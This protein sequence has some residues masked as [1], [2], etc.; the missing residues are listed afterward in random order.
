MESCLENFYSVSNDL[1]GDIGSDMS[2]LTQILKMMQEKDHQQSERTYAK[3]SGQV[4]ALFR[5][6]S[7]QNSSTFAKQEFK[8]VVLKISIF[9]QKC[10]QMFERQLLELSHMMDVSLQAIFLRENFLPF[11]LKK[12][13]ILIQGNKTTSKGTRKHRKEWRILFELTKTFKLEIEILSGKS[14]M[15]STNAYQP[16][17][18]ELQG[19]QERISTAVSFYWKKTVISKKQAE[20]AKSIQKVRKKLNSTHKQ[21]HPDKNK[22]SEIHRMIS[23][24][25]FEVKRLKTI[26]G[27]YSTFDF[28]SLDLDLKDLNYTYDSI[29][30]KLCGV[31]REPLLQDLEYKRTKKSDSDVLKKTIDNINLQAELPEE[32]ERF[33]TQ[34]L[35]HLIENERY[36]EFPNHIKVENYTCL[37]T[38][39]KNYAVFEEVLVWVESLKTTI[40]DVQF[41][42]AGNRFR[43]VVFLFEEFLRYDEKC[44]GFIQELERHI[45]AIEEL[46]SS[47]KLDKK[48]KFLFKL[49]G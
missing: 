37:K 42:V 44:Y 12:C 10:S 40:C 11:L 32:N 36:S 2:Y 41:E 26:F 20:I 25:K 1:L 21:A 43:Q 17:I 16:I 5:K 34:Q 48:V 14:S 29:C 18:D 45:Q 9:L 27:K 33:I 23:K 4:G 24:V 19:Y 28:S 22:L 13:K 3:L 46:V 8:N 47:D 30:F 39:F 35:N 31:S 7:A 15:S 6:I 38:I 49:F